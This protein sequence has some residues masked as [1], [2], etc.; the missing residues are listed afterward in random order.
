MARQKPN[1][2]ATKSAPLAV[3]R[4]MQREEHA[5][6]I[7]KLRASKKERRLFRKVVEG[8]AV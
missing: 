2:F 8:A 5:A 3:E 4:S 7:V 6:D 1:Y